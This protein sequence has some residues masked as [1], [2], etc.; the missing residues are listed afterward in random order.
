MAKKN[1]APKRIL[2]VK[3]P[4][5]LR[6]AAK[7][8]AAFLSTELGQ[9]VAM[10][11]LVALAGAFAT[12]DD[13]RDSLKEAA[14]RSRKSGGGLTDLAVH[15]GRAALLPALVAVHAKLPGEVR[16]EQHARAQREDN[17]RSVAEAVH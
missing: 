17:K 3:I 12:T 5:P 8:L 14:K 10:G 11:A 13:M 16:A 15:L 6:R 2:G 4:K 7:P 1:K 9:T